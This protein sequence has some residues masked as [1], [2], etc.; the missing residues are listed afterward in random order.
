MIAEDLPGPM[1]RLETIYNDVFSTFHQTSA[2]LPP[3]VWL[4]SNIFG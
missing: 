3:D 1:P 4:F 2:P